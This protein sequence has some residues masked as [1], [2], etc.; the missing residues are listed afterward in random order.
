MPSLA[1]LKSLERIQQGV[2]FDATLKLVAELP[3]IPTEVVR[4]FPEMA[5]YNVAMKEWHQKLLLALK[6]GP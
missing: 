6:G 3:A 5:K 1:D 2:A 4:R